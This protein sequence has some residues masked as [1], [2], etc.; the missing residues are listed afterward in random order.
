MTSRVYREQC[1]TSCF[2]KVKARCGTFP[3]HTSD[4]TSAISDRGAPLPRQKNNTVQSF[5]K[6]G[7]QNLQ[8]RYTR[9]SKSQCRMQQEFG[10][11][12]GVQDAPRVDPVLVTFKHKQKREAPAANAA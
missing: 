6:V 1:W 7:K 8:Y 4:G 2:R 3:E 12:Q 5:A 9:V 11:E 10:L